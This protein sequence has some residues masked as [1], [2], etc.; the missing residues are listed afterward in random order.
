MVNVL[1]IA[2]QRIHQVEAAQGPDDGFS[3]EK[4]DFLEKSPKTYEGVQESLW[5]PQKSKDLNFLHRSY[6]QLFFQI[7]KIIF[8]E[9]EKKIK[10]YF[11]GFFQNPKKSKFSMKNQ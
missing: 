4:T 7:R 5:K 1:S 9:I 6:P 10:K 8:F 3:G 11:L 2:T